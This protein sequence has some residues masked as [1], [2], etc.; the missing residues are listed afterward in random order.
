MERNIHGGR[1]ILYKY[2]E[3]EKER[4]ADG[5]DRIEEARKG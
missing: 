2:S 5:I 4:F 1:E 3:K